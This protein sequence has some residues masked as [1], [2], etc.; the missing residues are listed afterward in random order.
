MS[1][2]KILRRVQ[3]LANFKKLKNKHHVFRYCKPS[4]CSRERQVIFEE[5]FELRE[6]KN[7]EYLSCHWVEFYP[8]KPEKSKRELRVSP[9]KNGFIAKLNVGKIIEYGRMY[10]LN[11]IYVTRKDSNSSY[12]GIFNTSNENRDFLKALSEDATSEY[13]KYLSQDQDINS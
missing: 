7:E 4:L 1:F 3:F 13:K 11:G 10:A 12:S 9:K 2:I 5:A 6:S 8:N